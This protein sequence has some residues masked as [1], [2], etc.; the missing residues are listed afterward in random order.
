MAIPDDKLDEIRASADLVDVAGDYVRLKKSGSRYKALCPFHNEDTPSFSVDPE[1]NLFY[2]FGCQKGGDVFAFV[3]EMEGVGF[4]ESARMLADRFGI[5]LPEDDRD[6][7]AASETEAI[8]HALRFAARF[9][10]RQLTQTERGRPALEYLKDRGF[11]PKTIKRFGLGY[12]PDAW[13]A[14]L[15]AAEDE[16]IDPETLEQAG[17]VVERKSG[18]GYYD[19]YRNRVIFP[20]LS[21]VGKVLGFGGR[22]LDDDADQPKYINSPETRVYDKSKALYGLYQAKK[23]IRNEEEVLLVEGYTDVTSLHQA[24]VEHVVA[25]SGTALT[26][27][28]VQ[29]LDRYAKRIIL[30][31]DAD[32]AG[33]R[34]AVRGMD[35]VLQE[36]MGAYAV[37]LPEGED[38]DTFVQTEGAEAF[39]DYVEDHQRDMPSFRYHH[40]E[41]TGALDTPE[42]QAETM[43]D[44]VA[45]IARIP[46]TLMQETYLRR[47][48][49]VLGVPDIRLY[50]VLEEERQ[51]L[52]QQEERR[53]R[54]EARRRER[55]QQSAEPAQ[56]NGAPD[57]SSSAS[58]ED[59]D[60]A[61]PDDE[62][63]A[64]ADAE[65]ARTSGQKGAQ[66]PAEPAQEPLPEE[67]LLFRLMLEHGT[68]MVEFVLGNM[69]LNEFTDGV[70]RR[71][72]QKLIAMYQAGN[73]RP[74]EILE[75]AH[76][77]D[78][79]SLGASVM[80]DAEVPSKNWSRNDITVP[81]FN[82]KPYE[83]GADAMTLL[84]LDRVQ[85][86]IS[87]QKQRIYQATESDDDA[88]IQEEQSRLM[89]LY[90]LRKRIEQR[91]FLEWNQ[92][93][94]ARG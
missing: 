27:E 57:R 22:I 6:P 7:E 33:G 60:G 56:P 18:N 66:D 15:S 68:P 16:Q 89:G 51:K 9:F 32:E 69:A 71:L 85:D 62:A 26:A 5:P 74:Q 55:E 79:Q 82:Q 2:C 38:P 92:A 45:S 44:I 46:D 8:Y 91:E 90:D 31:Y 36:G 77:Q 35:R 23:A 19:R 58:G 13:D 48:S 94:P 65:N 93:A 87:D 28:Q 72:A 73:V 12:A 20:I 41:R 76:G 30:L 86:A 70:S 88:A 34:A 53:Q 1:K 49:D 10:Y 52:Q 40:A 80:V 47:A 17:L 61:A 75:G 42:G 43:H 11:V 39:A 24:G 84:K 54:R 78:L 50:E 83:A 63:A 67:R 29:T 3:Q 4:L 59:E 64:S 25:S 21:H 14:L 37:E 81:D